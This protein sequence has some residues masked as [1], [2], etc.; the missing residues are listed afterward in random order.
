VRSTTK[1]DGGAANA[2]LGA[3]GADDDGAFTSGGEGEVRVAMI[4]SV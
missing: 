3:V 2:T 1:S 4:I